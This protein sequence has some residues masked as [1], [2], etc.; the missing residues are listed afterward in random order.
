MIKTSG[1]AKTPETSAKNHIQRLREHGLE[2][3]DVYV[4][5]GKKSHLVATLSREGVRYVLTYLQKTSPKHFVSL[6][7]P[8]RSQ[9]WIS[10]GSLHPFFE[11]NLPEGSR[12]DEI[13]ATFGKAMMTENMSLLAIT[14][15]DAIGRVSVVP[16]GFP[17]DWKARF[18]VNI[19]SVMQ[20]D[21]TDS[22][23]VRAVR[24]HSAQG[25]AGV[26]PKLLVADDRV[27]LRAESWIIKH[28]GCD[29]EW[30]SVNEYLSMSAAR[31]CGIDVPECVLSRDGKSLFVNRFD[32]DGLGFEDMCALMGRHSH[33]KYSGSM[34]QLVKVAS[35][36]VTDKPRMKEEIIRAI[37]FNTCIG[38]GDAHLKNFGVLYDKDSCSM[39][40]FYDLV[41]VRAFPNYLDDIPALSIGNKKEWI[42]GKEFKAFTKNIN[43]S[44]VRVAEIIDEVERG[45]K[46]ALPLILRMAKDRPEFKDHAAS[47]A[48]SWN[49]GLNHI[50]GNMS[51]RDLLWPGFPAS[52]A[53]SLVFEKVA[54]PR[55]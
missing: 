28:D 3:L 31:L 21:R 54:K 30:L 25:V 19:D 10:E 45:V 15:N 34:E 26:Q 50:R 49:D 32:R 2:K 42:L 6:S 53:S 4:R 24:D 11:M 51:E 23:F 8:V 41:S 37:V 16:S 13:A 48:A 5:S 44:P 55:P 18:S 39:S 40:P 46:A 17:L 38:N 9:S 36:I 35:L 1:L 47:M 12:R 33:E 29:L 52:A 43:V 7:M 27:T 14:G 22:F 20:L